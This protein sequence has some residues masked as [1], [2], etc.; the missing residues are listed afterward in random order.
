[1]KN[2]TLTLL[3]VF[4][5][6]FLNNAVFAK[7]LT[8][9][10]KIG[11]TYN[12]AMSNKMNIN[13]NMMGMEMSIIMDLKNKYSINVKNTTDSKYNCSSTISDFSLK[14]K[15]I[16]ETPIPD[17]V[18]N[19][20]DGA[21][22]QQDFTLSK[23]GTISNQGAIKGFDKIEEAMSNFNFNGLSSLNGAESIFVPLYKKDFKIGDTC[24]VDLSKKIDS[25]ETVS[26]V[27]YKYMGALDTLGYKCLKF[28]FKSLEF[29]VNS[30]MNKMGIDMTINSDMDMNG[31]AYIEEKTGFLVFSKTNIDGEMRIALGGQ[32]NQMTNS[33]ITNSSEIL[34]TK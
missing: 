20:L 21:N 29:N 2:L 10:P 6:S 12:Y 31:I 23:D 19:K 33:T 28:N 11:A 16:P 18:S 3:F 5:F 4:S 1:M 24:L 27:S 22:F 25:V 7:K 8:L 14:F 34:R 15:T 26:R 17:S 30:K 32:Y 9:N 13:M